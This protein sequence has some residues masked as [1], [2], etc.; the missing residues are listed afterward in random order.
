MK[1]SNTLKIAMYCYNLIF[2]CVLAFSNTARAHNTINDT[3]QADEQIIRDLVKRQDQNLN[4]T[5][6]HA[7]MKA[8]LYPVLIQDLL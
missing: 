2:L 7:L 6:F 3:T 5:L 8:F 4:N 1:T